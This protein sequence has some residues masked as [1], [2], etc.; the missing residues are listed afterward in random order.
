MKSG[1]PEGYNSVSPY[2]MVDNVEKEMEFLQA[3]FLAEIKEQQRNAEGE[4]WH[5]EARIRD[6]IVMLGKA[7]KDYPAGQGMLYLWTED[8]DAAYERALKCKAVS[9]QEP[10][11]QFY[12][13]REAGI[14]DPQGNTWWIARETEKLSNKEIERRLAEQRKRRM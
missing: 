4:I 9:V 1:A 11:D 10:T 13:N 2:L 8:V 3:V 6:T 5:A 7:Q 14:R 12:G